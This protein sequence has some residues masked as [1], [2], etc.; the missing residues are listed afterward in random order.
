M[1]ALND[2]YN[3]LAR[4]FINNFADGY[5]VDCLDISQKKLGPKI[6][7]VNS[8]VF[9]SPLKQFTMVLIVLTY[10]SAFF[11]DRHF[12]ADTNTVKQ[13][14]LHALVYLGILLMGVVT[15]KK[16][17]KNFVDQCSLE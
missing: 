15:I 7:P 17:G 9:F 2:G 12:T 11:L 1:G 4:Y 13:S 6:A 5:H 3:S 14:I 16:N 8:R 10:L